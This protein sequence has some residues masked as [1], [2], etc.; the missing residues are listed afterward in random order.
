MTE[1]EC[2]STVP[3]GGCDQQWY[4]AM[5]MNPPKTNVAS[6]RAFTVKTCTLSFDTVTNS[7]MSE[8]VIVNKTKLLP[9]GKKKFQLVS[10][11]FFIHIKSF[12]SYCG[13]GVDS[14]SNR[15]EYQEHILGV[16]AAGA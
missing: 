14:T 2:K 4:C 11:E 13:P 12:E 15:D 1:V 3:L 9:C 7:L 10:L 5:K 6:L 16:N 8:D